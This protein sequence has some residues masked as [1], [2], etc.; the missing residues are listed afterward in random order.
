MMVVLL[1]SPLTGP[2]VWDPAA[3]ELARRGIHASVPEVADHPS[4]TGPFWQQHARSVARSLR[5]VD[6]AE[7]LVLVGH[8]GAGQLLP[9]IRASL[10]R[11][12]AVYLFVDAG[13]P[14]NGVSRLDQI[15]AE[16]PAMADDLRSLLE[17]GGRFPEWTNEDLR[18]IVPAD[19]LRRG[20]V[21]GL[22]PRPL[23]F[24][25]EPI[26]VFDGW[27][28]A[29]CGYIRLSAPYDPALMIARKLGWP[30]RELDAGHFH[31]LVEPREVV[32][33]MLDL[34][35]EMRG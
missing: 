30:T 6:A 33:V 28:D 35:A 10:G 15:R 24:F 26:E 34:L 12:V 14:E 17:Q 5:G 9:A 22:R 27:P 32:D 13:I 3:E 7:E 20:L 31:M 2:L 11:G 18:D 4:A 23:G 29:P 8:S 16:D 21:E 25:T 1:H 19:G